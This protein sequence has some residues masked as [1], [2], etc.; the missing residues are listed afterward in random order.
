MKIAVIGDIHGYDKG[1]DKALE[2]IDFSDV[3]Q[4][5]CVG[6]MIDGYPQNNRVVEII[7][8][9]TDMISIKGNHDE[10]AIPGLKSENK[11]WLLTLPDRVCIEG[12][13]FSHYSPRMREEHINDIYNAWN[14]FD[15]IDFNCAVV[16]HA[17]IQTVYRYKAE[18][19]SMAEEIGMHEEEINLDT[20]YRHIVVNPSLAYNRRGSSNP[21][22]TIID[23][24]RM[25]VRFI[26]IKIDP[27]P[28]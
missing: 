27:I 7:R 16:G 12:W 17:H 19:A 26:S 6:D 28:R 11:E 10:L 4:I 8:G 20:S 15:D 13:H 2:I 24:D 18:M 9:R 1:L 3:D 22:F 23:T 21:A 25:S 14:A 5:V